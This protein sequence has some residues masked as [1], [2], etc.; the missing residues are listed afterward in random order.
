VVP[1]GELPAG[2]ELRAFVALE[3]PEYMVPAAFVELDRIPLTV[4]GKLD[5]HALPEPDASV[6]TGHTYVA[7]R[8]P[9]EERVAEVWQDVLGVE[10]VGV[11]DGFFEL[12]GDSIRA[13]ALVGAL[14][15]AGFDVAVRDVFEHRTV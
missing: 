2:A 11:E 12:G 8:T 5:R 14:R 7:P 4:N 3:L 13:V 9:T 1:D 15:A 6:E 10:R